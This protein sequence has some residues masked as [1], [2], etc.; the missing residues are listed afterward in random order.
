MTGPGLRLRIRAEIPTIGSSGRSSRP[1]RREELEASMT[2]PNLHSVAV[3]IPCVLGLVLLVL[4]T[5]AWVRTTTG[6]FA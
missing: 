2:N 3:R 5:S 6:G 1:P 4:T